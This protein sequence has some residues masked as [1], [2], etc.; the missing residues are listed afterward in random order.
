MY[1][2]NVDVSYLI[3]IIDACFMHIEFPQD[4]KS[5]INCKKNSVYLNQELSQEYEEKKG[6]HDTCAAGLESNRS[7]LE[8]V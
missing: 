2:V 7:K 6:L 8:Q 1:E 3:P 5:G 4:Q